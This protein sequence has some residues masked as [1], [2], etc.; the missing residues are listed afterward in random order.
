MKFTLHSATIKTLLY[1]IFI[2]S[3]LTFTL[4]SAT[5][6]T[7]LLYKTDFLNQNLHYTL[8][9]LKL[10]WVMYAISLGTLFTLHS[11]TIKTGVTAVIH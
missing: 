5:I 1:I 6:K 10:L 11:A 7:F 3:H 9:L 4:H 8:L 2:L